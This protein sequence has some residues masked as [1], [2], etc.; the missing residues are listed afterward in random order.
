M[1][2]GRIITSKAQFFKILPELQVVIILKMMRLMLKITRFMLR[3]MRLMLSKSTV[4][5]ML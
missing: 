4:A 5:F 2:Q 1:E 3:M